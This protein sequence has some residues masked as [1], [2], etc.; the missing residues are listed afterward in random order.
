MKEKDFIPYINSFLFG[1]ILCNSVLW[2]DLLILSV[3]I[4]FILRLLY[5]LRKEY[6]G[7]YEYKKQIRAFKKQHKLE[8]LCIKC[9]FIEIKVGDCIYSPPTRISSKLWRFYN[10]ILCFLSKKHKKQIIQILKNYGTERPT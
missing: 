10:K 1:V 4:L 5:L 3:E 2:I 8:R 6:P 9:G 7:Y